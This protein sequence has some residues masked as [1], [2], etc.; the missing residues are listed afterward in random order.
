MLIVVVQLL[1]F[2]LYRSINTIIESPPHHIFA[3]DVKNRLVDDL[4]GKILPGETVQVMDSLGG[5]IHAL[6]DLRCKQP[7]RFVHDTLFFLG[8]DNPY[9]KKIRAE[10]LSDLQDRPPVFFVLFKASWPI[11]G[12]ERIDS[13]VELRDWLYA[14]YDLEVDNVFYHLYRKK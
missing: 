3:V 7:T 2:F 14:N 13:F 1:V 10:F 8:S 11:R 6:Y 12:Y 9:R 5:G 4:S